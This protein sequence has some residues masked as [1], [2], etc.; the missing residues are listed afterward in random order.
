LV[1]GAYDRNPD[2]LRSINSLSVIPP[3][4]CDVTAPVIYSNDHGSFAAILLV[5]L[6]ELPQLPKLSVGSL[7]RLQNAVIAAVVCP[8]VSL[9]E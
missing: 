2:V 7:E 3:L 6:K 1:V 9:V 8:I 4:T 5:A